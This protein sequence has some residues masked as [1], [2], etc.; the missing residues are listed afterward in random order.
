MNYRQFYGLMNLVEEEITRA[1]T[2]VFDQ[3][4][5]FRTQ[6]KDEI[7]RQEPEHDVP[8]TLQEAFRPFL[9][10]YRSTQK[11]DPKDR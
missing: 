7:V 4:W 8:F 3:Y 9:A 1:P 5:T 6:N 10:W 2:N 11:K